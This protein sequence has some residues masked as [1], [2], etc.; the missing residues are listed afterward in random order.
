MLPE[1][2]RKS[3]EALMETKSRYYSDFFRNAEAAGEAEGKAEG[4]AEDILRVLEIRDVKV[5]AEQR[6][7]VLACTDH[8]LLDVWLERAVTAH[9]SADV[10][11]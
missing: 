5:T 11:G 1:V 9:T 8:E 3:L 10:I 4:K 2:A 7:R 6:E